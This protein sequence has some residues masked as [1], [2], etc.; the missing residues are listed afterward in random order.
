MHPASTQGALGNDQQNG[1]MSCK[2]V[3]MNQNPSVT[4]NAN[5]NSTF[6]VAS[7]LLSRV[8]NLSSE[9]NLKKNP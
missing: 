9:N 4:T 8:R 1:A 5:H 3:V 7:F 6:S 2:V